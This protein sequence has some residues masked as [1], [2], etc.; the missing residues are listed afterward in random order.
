M[1]IL[2]RLICMNKPQDYYLFFK[3]KNQTKVWEYRL[4]FYTEAKKTPN[5]LSRLISKFCLCVCNVM[6]VHDENLCNFIFFTLCVILKCVRLTWKENPLWLL[7]FQNPP[8]DYEQCFLFH[9]ACSS[10]SWCQFVLSVLCFSHHSN[11][12]PPAQPKLYRLTAT[13]RGQAHW[14]L[15]LLC[16]L[17]HSCFFNSS[18]IHKYVSEL[19]VTL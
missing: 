3:Q 13:A 12:K 18:S 5:V 14:I 16:Q 6:F 2:N 7:P 19:G 8:P 10:F 17:C 15:H 9:S 11:S 4:G 1:H